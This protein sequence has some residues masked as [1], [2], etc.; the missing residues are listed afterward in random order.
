MKNNKEDS[1]KINIYISENLLQKLIIDAKQQAKSVS[2]VYRQILTDYYHQ[3][4]Q[5]GDQDQTK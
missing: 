2:Q 1:K 4:E 3:K 5:G